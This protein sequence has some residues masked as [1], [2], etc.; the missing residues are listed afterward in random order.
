M[1]KF[2]IKEKIKKEVKKESKKIVIIGGLI[3]LGGAYY[4]RK[5]NCMCNINKI[6]NDN[7]K[8]ELKESTKRLKLINKEKEEL[9]KKIEEFNKKRI[10]DENNSD[11]SRKIMNKMINKL[12]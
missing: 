7:I 12:N 3:G 1:I 2:L 9:E 11:A 10:T 4:F 6:E 5:R 8:E